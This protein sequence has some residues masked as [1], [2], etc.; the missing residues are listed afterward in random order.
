MSNSRTTYHHSGGKCTKQTSHGDGCGERSVM[1]IR[2]GRVE[3]YH[4]HRST[5]HRNW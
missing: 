2:T 1:D 4:K 3:S 5:G